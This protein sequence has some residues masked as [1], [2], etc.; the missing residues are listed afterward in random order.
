MGIGLVACS[1]GLKQLC[2]QSQIMA[3]A[4]DQAKKGELNDQLKEYIHSWREERS[5]EEEE[6]TRLKA[7]QA[8]RKEIRIEQEKKLAAQKRAEEEKN[9]QGGSRKKGR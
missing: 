2:D 3:S 9:S 4:E 5:K 7:K 8:K 1:L 6:L